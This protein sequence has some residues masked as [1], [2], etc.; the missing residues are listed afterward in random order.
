[1]SEADALDE[2]DPSPATEASNWRKP[3]ADS[4]ER[5]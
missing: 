4:A 1:M 2:T 5:Q 3:R